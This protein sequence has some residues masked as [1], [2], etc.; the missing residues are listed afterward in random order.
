MPPLPLLPAAAAR[1]LFL[2]AQGLL[3]D[4]GR[5]ATSQAVLRLVEDLGFVQLD[6]INTVAR[7]HDLILWSRLTGYTP[8]LLSR[9]LGADREKDRRLFEH[10]THDASAIPLASYPHWK[11]RFRADAARL[12]ASSWWRGQLGPDADRVIAHVRERIASEGPLRSADF[13]HPER[14]GPWWGWKP[15]KAA[16]DYLW[17]CGELAVHKRV[18]FHKVYDL[19]ERALPQHHGLPEPDA[20]SLIEWACATAAER[21]VVFTAREL[22][23]FYC[24]VDVAEARAFCDEGV[25]RGRLVP[26]QVED[27]SGG[28]PE[29]AF[30]LFD[31]E[32]RLRRL[33]EPPAGL[34]LLAPFDPVIR[35]RARCLRR[36]GFDYRFEAFTPSAARKYGYYVLPIL[37]GDALVGRLSPQLDRTAG[38]LHV[39]GLWWEPGAARG[40]GARARLRALGEAVEQLARFVGAAQVVSH[41][42][43]L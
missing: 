2:G 20:A 6:S 39:L 33:P 38:A 16:L 42:A 22:A 3:A 41:V 34:R 23:A 19:A 21:L 7:A 28:A 27:A 15:Q 17:R 9:L 32:S 24:A 12:R 31:Y 5:R 8:A 26:V 1:R 30:A 43:G 14:R 13:E 25:A 37:E 40:R 36:F 18:H 29:R 4:P 10:W 11:R 35:D